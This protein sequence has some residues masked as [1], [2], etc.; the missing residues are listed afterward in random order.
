[1]KNQIVCCTAA[2]LLAAGGLGALPAGT[3]GT[4][5]VASAA[6]YGDY[7]YTVLDDGTVEITKYTGSE[8]NLKIPSEIDGK[9]VTS[10]GDYSFNTGPYKGNDNLV[11]LTVPDS[12]TRI[13]SYSFAFS[14]NLESVNI[15]GS[16][17]IIGDAAFYNCSKLERLKISYGVTGIGERAFFGCRSL[18][19][20]SIPLSVKWIGGWAF[21]NCTGFSSV[22]IPRNVES[23]YE[24]AF[25]Y[26]DL[27]EKR[28]G[29]TI[30]GYK[31]TAAEEYA[32][33]CGFAFF[34]LEEEYVSG[35]WKYSLLADGTAEIKQ[36]SGSDTVVDVPAELDGKK[37]TS[38]GA[39][40]A[41]YN[42][43][44]SLTE[45][46]L[47]STLKNIGA[48]AFANCDKLETI[49]IPDSVES[50]GGSAFWCCSKLKK[51]KLPDSVRE[52]GAGAFAGCSSLEEITLSNNLT[53]LNTFGF[54]AIYYG[55]LYGCPKLKSVVIPKSVTTI[56]D[57]A[58]GYNYVFIDTYDSKIEKV[59]GFTIYGYKGTAA[60]EYAT[61]NGF[62][63]VDLDTPAPAK[64]SIAKATVTAANKVYTGKALK[65]A[66]TVKLSGKTL[67]SGT[68]YS[69]AYKNNTKCG[70]ATVTVTGK[71]DYTGTKTGS[72]IIKPKKVAAKKLT[73]PKTKQIKLTWTKAAGGVTGYQVQIAT[74]KA[75]SKGKKSVTVAK[76]S[77]ASKTI[78]KL[79]KGTKYFAR[80]RAYKT[81]GKTKYY[82]AW[83]AVKSV[84]CK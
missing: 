2:L 52:L 3:F 5:I 67:K 53:S 79:K 6:T 42:Y 8:A 66:V 4:A 84:K 21:C 72:F 57:Y 46:H 70:K 11:N 9:K 18:K 13:G 75:F 76:A 78:T 32:K 48:E 71:G 81:V 37:V 43:N 60:E 80:V 25:G 77:A 62:I 82:G 45:V 55:V 56:D 31:G 40:F 26:I 50:I 1:M 65:P 41:P 59:D 16:V 28:D 68:D 23:I 29:F 74:N 58:V 49:V 38:I 54:D 73:S 10:I 69:V 36:Y 47:P 20:I 22:T 51:V 39:V 7:E 61:K 44:G 17:N 35:D 19:G 63:F 64:K 12:V 14:D 33:N 27:F 24:N 15:P 30:G 83:S 34:D